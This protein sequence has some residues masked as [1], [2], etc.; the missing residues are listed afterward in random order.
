[1]KDFLKDFSDTLW[2]NNERYPYSV[3]LLIH[4]SNIFIEINIKNWNNR[5]EHSLPFI[6]TRNLK[7]DNGTVNCEIYPLSF[8]TV[9]YVHYNLGHSSKSQS[10]QRLK[11]LPGSSFDPKSSGYLFTF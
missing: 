7:L 2:I 10:Q 11:R 4:R 5:N 8:V 6:S 3:I 1:M 9:G